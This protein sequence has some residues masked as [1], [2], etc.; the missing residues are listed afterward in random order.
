M[1]RSSFYNIEGQESIDVSISREVETK[2]DNIKLV[3]DNIDSIVTVE[4]SIGSINVVNNNI[5]DVVTVS[6]E[7]QDVITVASM[8]T[9]ITDLADISGN[10]VTVAGI[11]DEVVTVA[12]I[13]ADV[14]TVASNNEAMV[15][16]NAQVVPNITEI[17]L[18][19]D[20]AVIATAKAA[21][22]LASANAS[23][24]SRQAAVISETNV[25]A[26][27]NDL[28]TLTVSTGVAGSEV[29]YNNATNMLTVPRGAAGANGVDGM[30]P[31]YDFSLDGTDLVITLVDHI[32]S[33]QATEGEW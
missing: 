12:N 31:V 3:A 22:A 25:S 18:A 11:R 29:V 21:E 14:T 4:P 32:P 2:Y 5:T 20:N 23:E 24:A 27:A 6:T 10:L 9:D 8:A 26:I 16:I 17:L 15:N 28:H 30:T 19:D 33:S 13:S 1:R 7:I